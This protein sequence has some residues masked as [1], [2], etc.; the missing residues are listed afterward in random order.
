MTSS[1]IM[2]VHH[3]LR[4]ELRWLLSSL[5]LVPAVLWGLIQSAAWIPAALYLLSGGL[6]LWLAEGRPSVKTL[7]KAKHL[8]FLLLGLA[9]LNPAWPWAYWVAAGMLLALLRR[10]AGPTPWF[11]PVLVMWALIFLSSQPLFT[12]VS[13]PEAHTAPSLGH[14]SGIERTAGPLSLANQMAPPSEGDRQATEIW[15]SLIFSPFGL[16]LPAGYGDLGWGRLGGSLGERS[17]WLLWGASL[18]LWILGLLSP[19]IVV[20]ALAVYLFMFLGLS[21]LGLGVPFSQDP[22]FHLVAGAFPLTLFF[23]AQEPSISPLK[24]SAQGLFGASLGLAGSLIAL[25]GPGFGGLGFG[26]LLVQ[27][28]TPRL[29]QT[30]SALEPKKDLSRAYDA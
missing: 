11:H 27:S 24:R 17:G 14:L 18:L 3:P 4:Q 29:D 22:L 21:G 23:L 8:W 15:N 7:L 10:L 30:F 19:W 25:F 5:L 1:G 12:A 20:P 9:T 13:A 6:S 26:L 28:L 2:I 16:T